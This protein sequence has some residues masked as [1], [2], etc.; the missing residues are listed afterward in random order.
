MEIT[1]EL[2]LKEA[3]DISFDYDN[4]PL[5]LTDSGISLR[6]YFAVIKKTN[7]ANEGIYLQGDQLYQ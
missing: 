7:I 4:L 2:K 5:C 1:D 6:D 3:I